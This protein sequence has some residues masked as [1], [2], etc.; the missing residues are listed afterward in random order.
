MLA[1]LRTLRSRRAVRLAMDGL[2]LIVIFFAVSLWQT[3]SHLRGD[4][5]AFSLRTL[6][7]ATVSTESLAGKPVLLA[8]W[9]PWCGVCKVESRN[10]SWVKSLVGERAHVVSVASEYENLGEVRGYVADQ[11]V[12]YPVLLG[13]R[14]TARDFQVAAFPTVF[15]LDAEGRIT[16]SVVGYTTTGGL[17]MRLLF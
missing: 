5:P 11:S 13:G 10:I 15:F 4:A 12:D 2:V 8:F 6:D 9:A 1:K 16:G 3:R 14:K 17:L 7:G